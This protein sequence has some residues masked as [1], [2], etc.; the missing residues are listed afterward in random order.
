MKTSTENSIEASTPLR[1]PKKYPVT[2]DKCLRLWFPQLQGR[3]ADRAIILKKVISETEKL[4]RWKLNG[5]NSKPLHAFEPPA[6]WVNTTF[7][8]Q[9]SSKIEDEQTFLQLRRTYWAYFDWWKSETR[10]NAANKSWESSSLE[11]RA[12]TRAKKKGKRKK[13]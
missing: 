4:T 3:T 5:D 7:A 8:K 6:D 13:V 10:R 11:K 1:M 9:R 2:L 12:A